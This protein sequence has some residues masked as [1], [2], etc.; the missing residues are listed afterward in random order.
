MAVFTSLFTF[1]Q[2]PTVSQ[3]RTP[4]QCYIRIYQALTTDEARTLRA[5]IDEAGYT[6]INLST[7]NG[8]KLTMSDMKL[9]FRLYNVDASGN[10]PEATDNTNTTGNAGDSYPSVVPIYTC[11]TLSLKDVDIADECFSSVS[12]ATDYGYYVGHLYNLQNLTCSKTA[13]GPD[14]RSTSAANSLVTMTIPKLGANDTTDKATATVGL[15]TGFTALTTIDLNTCAKGDIPAR[16]FQGCT[17]LSA[18]KIMTTGL[19]KVGDYAFQ[20]CTNLHKISFPYGVT[21]IGYQA[22]A[23]CDLTQLTLPNTL[24]TIGQFAFLSNTHLKTVKIPASV[25]YIES[26]AFN[27]N[28]SLDNVWLLGENT[29]AAANAFITNLTCDGFTYDNKYNSD[30]DYEGTFSKNHWQKT[31]E[32]YQGTKSPVLLHVPGTETARKRYLNP[33]L[34]FVNDA[35]ALNDLKAVY[36]AYKADGNYTNFSAARDAWY[37][38]WSPKY[39][40]NTVY[41]YMWAIYNYMQARYVD[42][43]RKVT[44]TTSS[45]DTKEVDYWVTIRPWEVDPNGY[46]YPKEDAS[47]QFNQPV[48]YAENTDYAGWNQF[49]LAAPDAYQIRDSV[50]LNT[51]TGDRWYSLC[52]PFPLT[53]SQI[54]EAF[55]GATEVCQFTKVVKG[56]DGNITFYFT[57]DVLGN[58]VTT[59]AHRPY[60]IRPELSSNKMPAGSASERV[61]YDTDLTTAASLYPGSP[62]D[63]ENIVQVNFID[64]TDV[65]NVIIH[66]KAYT[67]YGNEK[68]GQVIPG[69]RYFWAWNSTQ[70]IGSFFHTAANMGKDITWNPYTAIVRPEGDDY[71]AAAKGN[72]IMT[73]W[74]SLVAE[75]TTTKIVVIP[76]ASTRQPNDNR[77]YHINGQ[78]IGNSLEGL[79]KGVY[80]VNGKKYIV[81]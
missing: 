66:E 79:S 50:K 4:E 49:L 65:N 80:I 17:A 35:D 69:N 13:N 33:F 37:A 22:F 56:A 74:A 20:G 57:E 23:N 62:T 73:D 29:K 5:A 44:I 54:D 28:K 26:G 67:F 36:E 42:A 51:F 31:T 59:H 16:A 47:G 45:G 60:M 77:V 40:G 25:T 81:R 14:M 52:L 46:H 18:V 30:A 9:L 1:A 10:N 39:P 61:I 64:S 75:N 12:G 68:A 53:R 15:F 27:D 19:K 63:L 8:Y 7:Q 78:Y 3:Y 21:D 6:N 70:N 24:Q 11:T 48:S 71:A 43:P 32:T 2:S 76:A 34:F 58:G 72:L 55:G 41:N 38:T